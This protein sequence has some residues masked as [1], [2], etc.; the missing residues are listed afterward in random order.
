MGVSYKDEGGLDGSGQSRAQG[1]REVV[2]LLGW[3]RAI[4]L[5]LAHPLVAAGVAEHSGFGGGPLDMFGARAGR[6]ARCSP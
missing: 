1:Q 5:Q 4:L 3:G 6:L 2:V